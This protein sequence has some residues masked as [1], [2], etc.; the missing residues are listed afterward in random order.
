MGISENFLVNTK[1]FDPII[2]ALISRSEHP[3]TISDTTLEKM[4]YENPSDLL[5]LHVLRGLDIIHQDKTPSDLYFKMVDPDHTKEAIAEGVINGYKDLFLETPD[6]HKKLP[7]EIQ[8]KLKEYFEGKKTDL[9][10]KYIANTFHKL[11]SYAGIKTVEEARDRILGDELEA[12]TVEEEIE[13]DDEIEVEVEANDTVEESD[14]ADSAVTET[15]NNGKSK[16]DFHAASEQEEISSRSVEE[17]LFGDKPAAEERDNESLKDQDDS[18]DERKNLEELSETELQEELSESMEDDGSIQEYTSSEDREDEEDIPVPETAEKAPSGRSESSA[19]PGNHKISLAKLD[20][21]DERIQ[22]AVVRRA[23][24]L[25]KL[26]HNEEALDSFE[27]MISYFD[28]TDEAFLKQ[29]VHDA[30]LRRV[31]LVKKLDQDH[32]LLPALNEVI[33]RFSSSDNPEYYEQ[34]SKAMLQK[35]ELLE[36]MDYDGQDLLPLYNRIINRLEDETDPYI[37]DKV[38]EIYI[39]RLTLLNRADDNSELLKALNQSITRFGDTPR[40]RKY[41]EETMFRKAEIL[42]EMNRD[43]EALDAYTSFLE[44]FGQTVDS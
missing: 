21:S 18:A 9:I 33:R 13:I 10:I 22:K 25:Y 20:T 28:T 4:G 8:E 7:G 30:V 2:Q 40:F 42:E 35:A 39:R 41:L 5:V 16:P 3:E 27:E 23:E 31:E 19:L 26:G 14:S 37:Q 36:T 32:K 38:N 12:A 6:I 44:E 1:S 15:S 11:V 34:A 43:E 29:A 24:L 17:I